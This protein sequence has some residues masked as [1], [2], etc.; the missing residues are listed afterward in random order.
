M[1]NWIQNNKVIFN[2]SLLSFILLPLSVNA[3]PKNTSESRS[4][5]ITNIQN[6]ISS[7]I[8]FDKVPGMA[9]AL[10][11]EDK[12][13]FS[14]GFGLSNIETQQA[15]TA[16]TS[17]WLGSVS[18]T[19]VGVAIMHAQERGL[20]NLNDNVNSLLNYHGGFTLGAP[21][22]NPVLLKHLVT[23]TSS[24]LDSA[25]YECAYFVEQPS[26][27]HYNYEN[28]FNNGN[29]DETVPVSLGGYLEAYL[30]SGGV[31][32]SA[33]NNFLTVNPG[34]QYEYSN[35]GAALAGY[36]L[37]L[38]TGT[39]LADYAKTHIFEPLDMVNTSWRLSDLD[40]ANIAT[41][42]EWNDENKKMMPLPIYS[43]STWPDGGLRSSANDLA[44]YLMMVANEGELEDIRILKEESVHA[45]LSPLVVTNELTVGVF[46]ETEKQAN[47]QIR[48][49][50]N[51]GD[52]GAISY[53]GFDPD[54]KTGIV[55]VLN[56]IAILDENAIDRH[57]L[58]RD[59]LFDSAGE[60]VKYNE[61]KD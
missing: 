46:W 44:K 53:I 51:G 37:Q 29:C 19:A 1:K 7:Y 13:I 34:S 12:I 20:I 56:G 33:Q 47:G 11:H 27:Q 5:V 28:K 57:M 54:H 39:S 22:L 30:S 58:L 48:I 50:H 42:Y 25:G 45:M 36:S 41:P 21:F 9:V 2:I 35:V 60:L 38:A 59:L 4:S 14:E 31:Y 52:P 32:Y 6:A 17:F 24:I 18:K 23:H 16:D 43:L 3:E 8:K 10:I 61:T 15:V 26:G 55:L 49:G 40:R